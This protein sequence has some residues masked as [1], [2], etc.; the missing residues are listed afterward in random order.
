MRKLDDLTGRNFGSWVVLSRDKNGSFSHTKWVCKCSCGTEKSVYGNSLR[1]GDTTS[2]GCL[3][4]TKI[5]KKRTVHSK[6]RIP[7]YAV[8]N[9][10]LRRCNNVNS[11]DYK[12]YGG[13]GISV[14]NEWETF[15]VF[16]KDMGERP[17]S[18]HTIER[19]DNDG[20]YERSNCKW[21]TR[22]VQLKNRRTYSNSKTGHTGV[23]WSDKYKRW[24]STIN[25]EGKRIYLGRFKDKD[26][27]IKARN[28]AELKY[29]GKSS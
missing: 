21:E 19:I 11:K 5:R 27:A 20:P 17:S 13:R 29:W 10:M 12:Y 26:L 14:S 3:R 4:N 1:S 15:S 24:I 28:D 7:E 23:I 9:A 18:N 22:S 25:H 6:S 16:I 2:C 8:W